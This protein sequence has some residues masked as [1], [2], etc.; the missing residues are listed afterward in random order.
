MAA[1]VCALCNTAYGTVDSNNHAWSEVEYTWADDDSEVTAERH[2]TREGCDKTETEIV[3]ATGEVTTVATCKDKQVT[4][5]TSAAFSN[6]AFEIQTKAVE[7]NKNPDNH[8]GGSTWCV[9]DSAESTY[10]TEGY[11]YWVCRCNGCNTVLNT[12][13]V[14]YNVIPHDHIYDMK[15]TKEATCK[16]EGVKTFT[17]QY[18]GDVKTETIPK[19]GQHGEKNSDGYCSICGADL[20]ADARCKQCGQI[21]TGFFGGIVGFFHKIAYFFTHLFG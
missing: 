18:C 5:F 1:A 16:E 20:S 10:T 7:G 4:T 8:V 17:C 9:E 3:N 11:D 12:K 14:T 21:H 15:V 2:C 6:E 19:S 13:T